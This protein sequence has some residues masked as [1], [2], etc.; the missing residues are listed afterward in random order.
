MGFQDANFTG[1]WTLMWCNISL[2]R[3]TSRMKLIF[4]MPGMDLSDSS[5]SWHSEL[6]WRSGRQLGGPENRRGGMKKYWKF[7]DLTHFR[8]WAD[9]QWTT[10]QRNFRYGLRKWV[11]SKTDWQGW[12][13]W[14]IPG[15]FWFVPISLEWRNF[16]LGNNSLMHQ[17]EMEVY[18]IF[19]HQ[20][21]LRRLMDEWYM[22]HLSGLWLRQ[23]SRKPTSR[24]TRVWSWIRS[25]VKILL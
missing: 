16:A 9:W 18:Q 12:P 21:I 14:T 17:S 25:P 20:S 15:I 3:V 23:G 11:R 19:F 1:N 22:Y 8:G 4:P 5:K 2:F 7:P 10:W 13:F 6:N 24:K